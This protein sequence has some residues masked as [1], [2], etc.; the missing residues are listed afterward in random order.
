LWHKAELH[1]ASENYNRA[2]PADAA[3]VFD[4]ERTSDRIELGI[5]YE[6]PRS[7]LD[8]APFGDAVCTVIEEAKPEVVSFHFGLPAP[9][10]LARVKAAGCRVM[11]SDCQSS[12]PVTF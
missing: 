4:S 5:D 9:A 1:D 3:S 7:R 6:P 12:P 10:L 8:I 2:V 11:S